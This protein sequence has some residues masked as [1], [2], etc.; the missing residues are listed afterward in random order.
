MEINLL[1][2]RL[3][4]HNNRDMTTVFSLKIPDTLSPEEM[5]SLG[6]YISPEKQERIRRSFNRNHA[7]SMLMAELLLRSQ[8][9]AKTGLKNHELRFSTNSHGKP[10]LLNAPA[11]HYNLSH[12]GPHIVCAI[13]DRPVGIDIEE[14]RPVNLKIAER[15]FSAD[16]MHY[17]FKAPADMQARL[18]FE[19]WTKKEAYVKYLGLGLF[20]QPLRSFSVLRESGEV[21]FDRIAVNEETVCHMCREGTEAF[22]FRQI[23][24]EEL[25]RDFLLLVLRI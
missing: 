15:F 11:L 24:P 14:M 21:Y 6:D 13:S 10:M 22:M 5:V 2:K 25:I 9:C 12:S 19:I 8:L 16:E 18:F 20:S 7:Q 1:D 23:S 3:S 4:A 17:I